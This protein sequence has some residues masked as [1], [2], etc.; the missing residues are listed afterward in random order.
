MT[1]DS[2][3]IFGRERERKG[4]SSFTADPTPGAAL[5][6]VRGR[7]RHGKSF[8]LRALTQE[9][10]GL[11]FAATE[12]TEKP[13]LRLFAAA[14]VQ[15]FHGVAN[16]RFR[17]WNDAIRYLFRRYTG[18]PVLVVIDE[19]QFLVQDSPSLP[20]I[21]QRE[22][23]P[24]GTGQ[25]SSVRLILCGSAMSVMAGS[26]SGLGPL[27]DRTR[28]DLVIRPF[29]Y[30]DAADFWGIN[31]PGLAMKVHMVV[32]GTPAYRREFIGDDVP[33][34]PA[35]FDDWVIR[36]VLN[37]ATPLFYEARYLL[38]EETDIREP[39]LYHSVIAAIALGHTSTAAIAS[40]TGC[41]PDQ[42]ALPLSDLEGAG[43]VVREPDL[44]RGDRFTYRI[45]E[46]LI[47]FYA[48][49]MRQH[50][51]DLKLRRARSVWSAA[52][53]TFSTQIAGPHFEALCR[54]FA[55]AQGAE[56]F[57][58]SPTEV[59]SGSVNDPAGKSLLQIDVAAMAMPEPD[60]SR[61]IV[62][63]GEA[64][65]GEVM[66]L[67]H[68]RRLER[69]AGLL[70][71]RKFDTRDTILSCYSAAGF[72]DDLRAAAARDR[73]VRLIGAADLYANR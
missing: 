37:P 67:G 41:E 16:P 50:W 62:S 33:S 42:V 65:W 31:D 71:A 63:L 36:T 70:A 59:G 44:F 10:G 72:D 14:L 12:G 22:L 40:Y 2:E 26:V 43:L 15:H 64:K 30:T 20:S 35:D 25:D 3:R 68:L 27:R 18:E 13:A 73:R 66:G 48:A 9:T 24:G 34:G 61:R 52:Q 6:V 38:A 46:P 57:D 19:F 1:W 54:S 17:D 5:G 56:L 32:G 29:G 55:I 60:K 58:E 39:A 11:Y 28:L 23:G 53:H 45:T 21:I 7:R 4:L 51:A 69:A 8:L 49:I 47:T